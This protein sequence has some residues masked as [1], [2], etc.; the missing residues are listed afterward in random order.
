[1]KSYLFMMIVFGCYDK[2]T[3]LNAKIFKN[4]NNYEKVW[5]RYLIF[6]SLKITNLLKPNLK[7]IQKINL[8][9]NL[10]KTKSNQNLIICLKN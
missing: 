4:L 10:F 8:S 1:M 5:L 6:D 7:K 3:I 9:L 2:L